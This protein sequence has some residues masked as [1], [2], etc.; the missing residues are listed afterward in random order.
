VGVMQP[1]EIREPEASGA[2]RIRLRVPLQ[3]L[4][5]RHPSAM[6]GLVLLSTI[7]V[8]AFLAPVLSPHS[9]LKQDVLV[10]LQAPTRSHPFGTDPFGRDIL[11]RVLFG[12]RLSLTFGLLVVLIAMLAGVPLGIIAAYFGGWTDEIISRMIDILLAFPG[13]LLAL[14]IVAVLGPSLPNAMLAVAVASIPAFTRVVR[15]S[16]LSEG[17][18][19]YVLAARALGCGDARIMV[20]HLLPNIVGPVLVLATLRVGAAILTTTSLSFLGLGAQPP[21]PEWGEMLSG[22]RPFIRQAWW[23]TVFPGSAIALTVLAV[24]LLGD[25]F[26]DILDPKVRKVRKQ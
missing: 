24:N 10:A 7:V 19:E 20:R 15:G 23:L 16:V 8:L 2:L 12:G 22:A 6:I 11:A 5:W 3:R 25:G 26:R 17:S 9:P 4:I 18:R 13:F 1:V 14:V 21:T